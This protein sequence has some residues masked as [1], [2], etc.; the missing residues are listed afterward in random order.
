[1]GFKALIFLVANNRPEPK[2][3][4]WPPPIEQQWKSRQMFFVGL[5]AGQEEY[6]WMYWFWD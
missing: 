6:K 3:T 2:R 5:V 1:M 4:G